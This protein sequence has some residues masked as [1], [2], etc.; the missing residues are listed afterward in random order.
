MRQNINLEK[1]TGAPTQES[2]ETKLARSIRYKNQHGLTLNE[3]ER[4][5]FLEQQKENR[6]DDNPRFGH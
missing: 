3:K 5:Y 2:P 6:R 4:E 1:P